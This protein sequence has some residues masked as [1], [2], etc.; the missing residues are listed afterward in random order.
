M[1]RKSLWIRQ[2]LNGPLFIK[3]DMTI[4]HRPT[5]PSD[6]EFLSS[7]YASTRADEMDWVNWNKPQKEAFLRKLFHS[8]SRRIGNAFAD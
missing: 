6:D 8:P 4:S 3:I 2:V 7:V 5:L 1:R